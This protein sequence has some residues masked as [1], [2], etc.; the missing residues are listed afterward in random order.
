[1]RRRG[2]YIGAKVRGNITVGLIVAAVGA[3]LLARQFGAWFPDWLFT[4]PVFLIAISIVI[5]AKS[6]FRDFGWVV[7]A[8]VGT[9]FLLDKI[10]P[11]VPIHRFIWPIAI[12]GVGLMIALGGARGRHRIWHDQ[13][14]SWKEQVP[15]NPTNLI[16][17][18]P[19]NTAGSTTSSST[20]SRPSNPIKGED[21]V[22]AVAV[23]GGFDKMIFSKTFKGGEIV[24]IFGGGEVNLTKADFEKVATIEITAVFGGVKL[25]VPSNWS[26]RSELNPVFGGIDDKRSQNALPDPEKVLVLKGTV[27]FGGVDIRSY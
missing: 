5:G 14:D 19:S 22:D 11:E 8:A 27:I 2:V 4:W 25:T 1:L 21:V 23:F 10:Y 6:G 17:P 18:D 13:K 15:P 24:C 7:V 26:V 3:C 16:G 12:I 9:L 20:G